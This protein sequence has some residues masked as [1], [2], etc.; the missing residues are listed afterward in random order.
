DAMC[1]SSCDHDDASSTLLHDDLEKLR[2]SRIR[3]CAGPI[4][5]KG[6][7]RAV[8][9]NHQNATR[10]FG[11]QIQEVLVP[12]VHTGTGDGVTHQYTP[13]RDDSSMRSGLRIRN[14]AFPVYSAENQVT[15]LSL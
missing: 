11:G 4:G 14:T 1:R 3:K 10:C 9:V 2:N 15:A 12:S 5:R 6:S 7:D 8:V 13:K